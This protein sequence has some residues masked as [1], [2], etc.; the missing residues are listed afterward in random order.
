MSTKTQA[1]QSFMESF[2][3]PAY[4]QNQIPEDVSLPYLTYSKGFDPEGYAATVHV[5]YATESELIADNK[6]VEICAVIGEGGIQ[7]PCDGGQLWITLDKP[8][9]YASYDNVADNENRTIKH[10]VININ[11]CDFTI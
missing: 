7:I 5:F 6:A 1:L 8:K 11:I 3:I 9:W 10:R 2:D 4:P